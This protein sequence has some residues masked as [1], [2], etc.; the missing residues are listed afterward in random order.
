MSKVR[1][2]PE[3]FIRL[4]QGA[5]NIEEVAKALGITE[6]GARTRADYWRRKPRSVPLKKFPSTHKKPNYV[7]LR[8]LAERLAP[9]D[10]GG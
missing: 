1:M 9:K 10:N 2:S 7:A 6:V 8:H 3:E 4:W 5:N